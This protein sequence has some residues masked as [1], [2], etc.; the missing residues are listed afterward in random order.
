MCITNFVEPR[1][2]TTKKGKKKH[3]IVVVGRRHRRPERGSRPPELG[4]PATSGDNRR[5][6]LRHKHGTRSRHRPAS[7]EGDCRRGTGSHDRGRPHSSHGHGRS[8]GHRRDPLLR[9][10][11]APASADSNK[12]GTRLTVGGHRVLAVPHLR[13]PGR[14]PHGSAPGRRAG[15]PGRAR[16]RR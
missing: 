7:P 14:R 6:N 11:R 4:Y 1:C 15:L 2:N 12:A 16:R 10:C 8:M 13:H 3:S 5:R 9:P